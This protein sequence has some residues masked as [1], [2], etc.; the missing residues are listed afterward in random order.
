MRGQWVQ[1]S[2]CGEHSF[3]LCRDPVD[4][5]CS[6]CGGHAYFEIQDG[7]LFPIHPNQAHFPTPESG[8]SLKSDHEQIHS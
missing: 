4:F 2:S 7:G 3:Y 1:C 6:N 5:D 8:Q